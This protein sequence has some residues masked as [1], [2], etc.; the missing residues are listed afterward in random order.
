MVWLS[1]RGIRTA[2]GFVIAVMVAIGLAGPA[3]ADLYW[4]NFGGSSID[5]AQLNG[6]G[7][8]VLVAAAGTNLN[9]VSAGTNGYL[10]WADY[11]AN[12]IGRA[13]LDG[14]DAQPL[15]LTGADQAAGVTVSSTHIYWSEDG[16]NRVSRASID[17]TNADPN[18]VTG[19]TSPHGLAL[20]NDS[21]YIANTGADQVLRAPLTGGTFEVLA[22]VTSPQMIAVNSSHIYW[23]NFRGETVGRSDLDGSN[24]DEGFIAAPSGSWTYGVGVDSDYV[25]WTNYTGASSVGRARL[26]GTDVDASFIGDLSFAAGLAVVP[27]PT[28]ASVTPDRGTVDG[29]TR[30][31]VRGTGI[32]E[33]AVVTIGDSACTSAD[34]K[35]STQIDCTA[36]GGQLGPESVTITNPDGQSATAVNAYT[37]IKADPTPTNQAQHPLR[38]CATGPRAIPAAGTVRLMKARCRTDAG[39]LVNVKVSAKQRSAQTRGDLQYYRVIRKPNGKTLLRTFGYPLRIKVTWS[40][41]KTSGFKAYKKVQ[42]YRS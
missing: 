9:Q 24:P 30:L 29:G 1:K 25:Y 27:E 18:F 15:W 21:L 31:S 12:A 33:N 6:T 34:W 10:Y 28:I 2:V 40:A 42:R 36:P 17:G 22:N 19:L 14:S 5:T 32:F 23:T 38:S 11:N 7:P 35:G 20:A 41:S 4:A 3:H 13:K 8:Q 37:Y 26:D 39:Q 16:N